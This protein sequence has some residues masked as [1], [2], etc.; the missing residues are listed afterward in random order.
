M[1]QTGQ[2]KQCR[3]WSD[4][5]LRGVWSGSTLFA[6]HRAMVL[7]TRTGSKMDFK[8]AKY[9][10][11]IRC[12]NSWDKYGNQVTVIRTIKFCW[13]RYSVTSSD[14]HIL[15]QSAKHYTVELQ[16]LEHLWDHGNLFET[17]LVQ[18]TEG[19]PWWQ[20]R[21]QMDMIKFRDVFLPRWGDSNEFTQ[22]TFH[23]KIRKL[24]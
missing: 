24:P 10:K 3:P 20:V 19:Y 22:H 13:S 2:S 11:E 7:N 18:S 15:S 4:A 21:K 8:F 12:N 9:G 14:M 1:E 16:W 6:T 17:W 5:A 23:D